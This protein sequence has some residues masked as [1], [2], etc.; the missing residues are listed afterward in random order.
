LLFFDQ[1]CTK[2][3]TFLSGLEGK[4]QSFATCFFATS[5]PKILRETLASAQSSQVLFCQTPD[6]PKEETRQTAK[7]WLQFKIHLGPMTRIF[8]ANFDKKIDISGV[9]SHRPCGR[10]NLQNNDNFW[11]CL[12]PKTAFNLY[13]WLPRLPTFCA[14]S[15]P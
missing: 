4:V 8:F 13:I 12:E 3:H 7:T 11:L 10:R 2:M 5:P 14:N 9:Q 6:P 15:N 1:K